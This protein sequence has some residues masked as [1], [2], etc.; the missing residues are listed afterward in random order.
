MTLKISS[1]Q[2]NRPAE[3]FE[4]NRNSKTKRKIKEY[5]VN[6]KQIQLNV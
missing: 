2:N 4:T 5:K 6:N 3:I 1:G